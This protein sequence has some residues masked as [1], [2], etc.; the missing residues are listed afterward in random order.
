MTVNELKAEA[1]KLGYNL[2]PIQENIK[3]LPCVCGY[4][5]RSHLI[6][7][8]GE[9]Y[10]CQKCGIQ[11]PEGKNETEAKKLWNKMIEERR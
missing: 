7:R 9:F 1:K 2:I 11:S 4:N 8:T 3:F 5:R 10:E 6:T